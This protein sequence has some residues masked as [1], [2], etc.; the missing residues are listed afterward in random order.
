MLAVHTGLEYLQNLSAEAGRDAQLNVEIAQ[1]YTKLGDIQGNPANANL[2]DE[3]G[4]KASY[5]TARRML[6]GQ[7]DAESRYAY[8]SLLTHEGD[9]I[10]VA[11]DNR[12]AMQMYR[13][14]V[15]ALQELTHASPQDPRF[16]EALFYALNDLADL[17]TAGGDD[18]QARAS[19][20]QAL[21]QVRQL[22][23]RQPENVTYQR[24]LARCLSRFG[25]LEWN[26]G[27]WQ[28]AANAYRDSFDTYD[29]LLR[30]YPDNLKVRHSWI[31]GAN[32][33]ALS[34]EKM[35]RPGD[36]LA[37]YE[38]VAEIVARTVEI[39]PH[40]VMALRDQQVGYSNETRV[41]LKVNR[42]PE[43]AESSRRELALAQLLWSRNRQ[44]ATA[45][46]DLAGSEEH[47]A[48]VEGRRHQ[49]AAAIASEQEALRL[50]RAN[51]QSSNSAD[52]LGE[53]VDG[54]LRLGSYRLDAGAAH[55]AT[56][57]DARREAEK[58][59][60]ELRRLEPRLRSDNAEDKE[61]A[62]T[63]RAFEKRLHE[64][65]RY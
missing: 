61:R 9:L 38:R 34:D 3:Q 28:Q 59:L 25:D 47:L 8:S 55:P 29:R 23:Q 30:Q 41:L 37:L 15:A 4:A 33:V 27:R 36:A 51:L 65:E 5:E 10:S 52:N 18:A 26:A 56:M 7:R 40:N 31:A 19:Y 46:D 57:A 50:L 48:E 16:K 35:G 53:V 13:E 11:G 6:A 49:Y 20:E 32:N 44:D 43:A 62:A 60:Q 42:L 17:Q 14:A 63:L 22:V 12:T 58:T 54:L 24:N 1:A 45:A 39:D 64:P 2:G 21:E